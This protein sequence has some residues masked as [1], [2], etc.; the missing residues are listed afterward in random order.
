MGAKLKRGVFHRGDA[1]MAAAAI[2][3]PLLPFADA[4][5]VALGAVK[6]ASG[7]ARVKVPGLSLAILATGSIRVAGHG[8]KLHA[9]W[10]S[11]MGGA[12]GSTFTMTRDAYGLLPHMLTYVDEE[13]EAD[14][15]ATE[16]TAEQKS[17][18]EIRECAAA[19]AARDA[20]GE[21]SLGLMST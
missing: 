11:A 16:E 2:A 5:Q 14:G 7:A 6:L 10:D 8:V 21:V 1:K 12:E 19:R 13:D 9:A 4:A 3:E 18:R 20:S 17:L 15:L